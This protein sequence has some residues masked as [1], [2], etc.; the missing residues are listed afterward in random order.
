MTHRQFLHD[1]H[2]LPRAELMP[3]SVP[4]NSTDGCR[5]AARLK[6]LVER[7]KEGADQIEQAKEEGKTSVQIRVELTLG[8]GRALVDGRQVLLDCAAVEAFSCPQVE[9]NRW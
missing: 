1:G 4:L 6:E 8:S 5:A 7:R 3:C 9:L 2:V